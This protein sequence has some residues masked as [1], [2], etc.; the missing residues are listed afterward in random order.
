MSDYTITINVK[1]NNSNSSS[2]SKATNNTE[3]VVQG[4]S[5]LKEVKKA[6][7]LTGVA[8]AGKKTLNYLTTRVYPETGNRQLQDNINATKQLASQALSV[9]GAFAL[10]GV[11]GGL[12]AMGGI[13]LDYAL[14]S[15]TYQ[16]N[17][18]MEATTL[19]I[20]RERMGVG[21]MAISRSRALTQ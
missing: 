4:S 17:K 15:A 8:S 5:A 16:Y 14:Q 18:Q 2:L 21:G 13:A 10:G 1:G 11:A 12:V 6:V 3:Q 9:L 7:A 20:T 19:N